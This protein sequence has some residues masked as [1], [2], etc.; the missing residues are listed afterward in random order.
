MYKD[1]ELELIN[2]AKKGD[3]RAFEELII[4]YE[5]DIYNIAYRMLGNANDA[6]D[7]SQEVCIKIYKSLNIYNNK[8]KLYTWIYKITIN[9][10]IDEIR[11]NRKNIGLKYIDEN[12]NVGES[13]ILQQYKDDKELT[14]EDKYI[15]KEE[16][17]DILQKINMLDPDHRAVI[18]L[19]YINNLEYE[20]IA[21]SLECSLGT[22]KSRINRAKK[23]LQEIFNN[24]EQKEKKVRLNNKKG[25]DSH[26]SKR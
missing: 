17:S 7:V 2:K 25:G 1:D 4:G 22:V 20:E 8:S 11:K 18:I 16:K 12:I 9:T 10:C 5:K 13:E 3:I 21:E 26:E 15:K 6:E 19:R 24:V 14:P 23:K